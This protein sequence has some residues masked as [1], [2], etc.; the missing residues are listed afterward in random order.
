[1]T[2]NTPRPPRGRRTAI[3]V[4]IAA[5]LTGVLAGCGHSG[6]SPASKPTTRI[7]AKAAAS[8]AAATDSTLHMITNE[9]HRLAF[10]VTPGHQPAIVLDAGGGLDSSY[11]KKIVPELSAR[12]GSE[13]ITYDRAGMGA[14]DP[15][16]GPWKAQDAVSD[17]EAGLTALGATRHVVLVSHSEAGEIATYITGQHPGQFAGA[18]LVDAALP[19][20]STDTEIARVAAATRP[21]V[22]QI[23]AKDP[24]ARTQAERQLLAVAAGYVPDQRAYH[25][26]VWPAAVPADVIVSE[27]TPFPTSPPDAEAWRAAQSAF[28]S[29]APNRHLVT[30]AGSS[31]D[32]PLDRPDIVEAQIEAM[33]AT[34]H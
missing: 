17:L 12:T 34:V 7:P 23:Q 27:Q 29:E 1:M 24:K 20:F 5:A 4:G 30:A 25:Q 33:A 28:A 16:P 11:W 21:E 31:H 19:Q 10:H 32:I 3:A 15:V 26:A 2:A 13:I 14:S 6:G 8:T 18:V 22:E 9:G